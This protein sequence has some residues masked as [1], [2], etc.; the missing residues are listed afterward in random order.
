MMTTEPREEEPC[1]NIVTR[2]GVATE[3]GEGKRKVEEAYVSNTTENSPGFN[4][5]VEKETFMG[6]KRSF[7]D[8]VAYTSSTQSKV[9]P[10]K[11][12]DQVTSPKQDLD[13]GILKSFFQPYLKL[14]RNQ[15]VVEGL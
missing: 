15:M 8:V 5:Q 12:C 1:V 6:V 14:L 13:L 3:D 7:M 2:N 10:Q 9:I 11:D 4:I